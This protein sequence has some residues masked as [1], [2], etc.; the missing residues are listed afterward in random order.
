[1]SLDVYLKIIRPTEVYSANITH[2][3]GRMAQEAVLYMP[4]WRPEEMRFTKAYQIIPM[5]EKGLDRL[6]AKPDFFKSFNPDNGWGSYESLVK[7][8]EKYLVAC[9]EYPD[10]DIEVSR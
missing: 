5:L 2:N 8:V 6:K 7:F 1:M 10:A 9:K 3:L 4:L